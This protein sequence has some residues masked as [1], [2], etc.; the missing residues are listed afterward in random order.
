MSHTQ[1]IEKVDQH[2][3]NLEDYSQQLE[4]ELSVL[5]DTEDKLQ[6]LIGLMDKEDDRLSES[7]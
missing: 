4:I 5:P 1:V 6:V 7:D 2:H 3:D